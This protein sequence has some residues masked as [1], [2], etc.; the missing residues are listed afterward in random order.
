MGTTCSFAIWGVYVS[1][2]ETFAFFSTDELIASNASPNHTISLSFPISETPEEDVAVDDSLSILGNLGEGGMGEVLLVREACPRREVALKIA[3]DRKRHYMRAIKHEAMIMGSLEHPN[4]IPVHRVMDSDEHGLCMLMKKVD[5]KSLDEYGDS[6]G[7]ME[8][9]RSGIQILIQVCH[10]LEYAHNQGIIHRDIKP[11]NIMTGAFGEV[12]LLDWGT[13][14]DISSLHTA[15]K[16]IL[17]T[18]AYMAPE[19]LTGNPGLIKPYTDVYLLGATLHE[20]LTGQK[21]H[22]G[23]NMEEILLSVRRSEPETYAEHVPEQL[24]QLVNR[25]CHLVPAE[26]VQTIKGFREELERYLEQREGYRIFEEAQKTALL[27]QKEEAVDV[28]LGHFF[29]ARFGFEQAL[30]IIPNH[31]ESQEALASLLYQMV[32][33]QIERGQLVMAKGMYKSLPN[34][35]EKLHQ[36]MKKAIEDQERQER[37]RI[38]IERVAQD[39][40]KS[41]S[42]RERL[43]LT[44]SVSAIC[45]GM[46]ATVIIYDT[47]FEPTITPSRLIATMGSISI[48]TSCALL[49]GRKQLLA[50]A[51]SR[52]ISISLW[53]GTLG[54]PLVVLSSFVHFPSQNEAV[55]ANFIMSIHLIIV[56]MTFSMVHPAIRTGG[57]IGFG[58][59]LLFFASLFRPDFTHTALL[60][61]GCLAVAGLIL[62]WNK[63]QKEDKEE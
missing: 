59:L 12:Y 2:N 43:I 16:A 44:V 24:E 25:A 3:K 41:Q 58:A 17:G 63:E 19:M 14:L 20:M 49:F 36:R 45:L 21:R 7:D 5:G 39:Q 33:W 26:R 23:S 34:P 60:L 48:V 29:A 46:M 52:R 35:C 15:Q 13:A 18:P 47:I 11:E 9:I 4:I 8:W 28:R 62:D 30:R 10:A 37:K 61:S 6:F 57:M 51:V 38:E 22:S 56:A 1:K 42:K 54:F 55:V 27:F 53:L 32:D 50:N 40:D 31:S